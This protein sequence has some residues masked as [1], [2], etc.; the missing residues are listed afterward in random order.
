[1]KRT[2]A[3]G[4]AKR[5]QKQEDD[6]KKKRDSGK[7]ECVSSVCYI[8]KGGAVCHFVPDSQA[9]KKLTTH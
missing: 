7:W 8:I 2:Y 5:R 4:H 3:S 6:E 1:M 9:A